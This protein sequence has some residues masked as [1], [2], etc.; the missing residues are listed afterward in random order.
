[1]MVVKARGGQE[2][3]TLVQF[4]SSMFFCNDTD[5]V[6]DVS[7]IRMSN[8]DALLSVEYVTQDDTA[9]ASLHYEE[10]K[11]SVLFGPGEYEQKFQIRITKASVWQPML[12][13]S[14]KLISLAQSSLLTCKVHIVHKRAFPTEDIGSAMSV[15]KSAQTDASRL[16]RERSSEMLLARVKL[17]LEFVRK[18]Y[19][20]TH[21][22]AM[23]PKQLLT[24][25]FSNFVFLLQVRPVPAD[26]MTDESNSGPLHGHARA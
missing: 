21:V 19:A 18:C 25:A 7:V 4:A 22:R 13:F 9:V 14:V 5:G 1:M 11:G 26:V 23:T 6:V 20:V 12:R 8:L 24:D 3:H 10:A 16:V 2:K 15:L 17:F